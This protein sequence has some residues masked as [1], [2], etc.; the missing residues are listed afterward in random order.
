[1]KNKSAY[2]VLGLL[3]LTL[4][5]SACAPAE[6]GP[7]PGEVSEPNEPGAEIPEETA[8]PS[9]LPGAIVI[10]AVD[11]C[12]LLTQ[13]QVGAAFGAS[14]VAVTPQ[15]ESIGSECEYDF[16]A[17][18]TQLRVTFYEGAAAKEY[19][20]VLI[21]AAEESCDAFFEALF[22]VG[23]SEGSGDDLSATPLQ[24]LYRQYIA[25]LGSCMYV[26]TED[27]PEVGAN[28]NATE[29][30]FFNWSSNVAVLGDERVVEFTYQENLPDEVRD[31]LSVATDKESTYEIAGPYRDDILAGYTEILLGL[32]QEATN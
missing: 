31:A 32:L 21:N 9:E 14:V 17:E 12:T 23:L 8:L 2:L 11:P 4:V 19:F 29:T 28:V 30:I 3:S 18:G 1:M 20:A 25:V 5:L 24:D 6:A 26:H 27:R 16:E 10:D 22:S 15:S 7:G 13:E